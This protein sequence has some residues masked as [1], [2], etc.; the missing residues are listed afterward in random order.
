MAE[1]I[2]LSPAVI[3]AGIKEL[4]YDD[5]ADDPAEIVRNIYTAMRAVVLAEQAASERDAVTWRESK[6]A[7]PPS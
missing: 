3:A 5:G 4:R 7:H 6:S 1:N 2:E